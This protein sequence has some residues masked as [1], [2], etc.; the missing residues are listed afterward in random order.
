MYKSWRIRQAVAG[1]LLLGLWATRAQEKPATPLK[2]GLEYRSIPVS[3][4]YY[5]RGARTHA[6]SALVWYPA[7]ASAKEEPQ[8][9][10]PP[11]RP[12]F[13]VGLASVNAPIAEGKTRYPL[14]AL[15]HGTGGSALMMA[16]FGTALAANGY[17]AVAVNHPGNNGA[18]GY[19]AQGFSAWWE[20][21]RD[22]S[23]VIDA[24]IADPTF[25]SRIDPRRIGAAGFSLGGYTVIEIAGGITVPADFTAFCGSPMADNICKSPPE[26]PTLLEDFRR[27]SQ[28]DAEFQASLRHAS[29]SYRD[30]RVRAVFAMAPALGPAFPA[31]GLAKISIPVEIVAGSGDTNVPVDSSAKYFAATIPGAKLTIL[32]GKG[33]YVFLGTCTAQGRK[34]LPVLCD[35]GP[36]VDRDSVHAKAVALA[37]AF[38]ASNLK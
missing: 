37:L 4:P 10:G 20:R 16:W 18:E 36:G 5:W 24:M 38:F 25:G 12:L 3:K 8:W 22:L 34:A 1:L 13:G 23:T 28:S 31:A 17:I 30:P 6:L 7:A 11:E 14:V 27:L 26:F 29:D 21:A 15:S 19:T 32:P 9:V 35:D 33:H 2:V